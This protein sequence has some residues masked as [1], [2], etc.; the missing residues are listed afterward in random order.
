MTF[1]SGREDRWTSETTFTVFRGGVILFYFLDKF[2]LPKEIGNKKA[3]L[4]NPIFFGHSIVKEMCI[5]YKL[6]VSFSISWA[7]FKTR[8]FLPL[9][10]SNFVKML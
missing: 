8:A 1:K 4:T 9:L 10:V 6:F 7:E 3:S 2:W 5:R